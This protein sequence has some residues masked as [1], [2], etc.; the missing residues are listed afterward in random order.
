MPMPLLHFETTL[1][2]L[3]TRYNLEFHKENKPAHAINSNWKHLTAQ[4]RESV[5]TG[6]HTVELWTDPNSGVVQRLELSWP[7]K[8]F[9]PGPKRVVIFLKNNLPLEEDFFNHATHHAAD[10][11]VNRDP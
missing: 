6:P 2:R 7:A 11:K 8:L 4:R 9:R 5:K 3:S 10:R 1:N